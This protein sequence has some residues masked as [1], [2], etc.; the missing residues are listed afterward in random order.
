YSP[1]TRAQ[2]IAAEDKGSQQAKPSPGPTPGAGHLERPPLPRSFSARR[3]CASR[4]EGLYESCRRTV[5]IARVGE[6]KD[7]HR[8]REPRGYMGAHA[9]PLRRRRREPPGDGNP[10][11]APLNAT[12][13]WGRDR[14]PDPTGQNT[15]RTDNTLEAP[16]GKG[17]DY[18]PLSTHDDAL[19]L[20]V[21]GF[22]YGACC[23]YS[24]GEWRGYVGRGGRRRQG[25]S[26]FSGR[27]AAQAHH[28]L[29]PPI[30]HPADVDDGVGGG[31]LRACLE[32][33]S[34][35]PTTRSSRPGRGS[36]ADN[37]PSPSR[38]PSGSASSTTTP[39]PRRLYRPFDVRRTRRQR[40]NPQTGQS[41][42]LQ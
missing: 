17:A 27:A 18:R 26:G 42:R 21:R 22:L 33:A 9:G 39:R 31:T 10:G 38:T 32:L 35:R 6:P 13:R 14:Q 23:S 24:L 5:R 7:R 28:P 15:P 40:T 1:H 37:A 36:N 34:S 11:P 41:G 8:H 4:S 19:N 29:T 16:P 12:G 3:G 30:R 25:G 2:N 20:D